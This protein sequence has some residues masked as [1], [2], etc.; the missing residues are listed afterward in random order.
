MSQS[1]SFLEGL[2]KENT[3]GMS[4]PKEKQERLQYI[5]EDILIPASLRMRANV[6]YIDIEQRVKEMHEPKLESCIF[7]ALEHL[8]SLQN[9]QLEDISLQ[10]KQ[11]QKEA[12]VY[13]KIEKTRVRKKKAIRN[14]THKANTMKYAKA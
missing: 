3:V 10:M 9:E 14:Y 7:K 8:H 4:S 6:P 12:T 11:M 2:I 1:G 13:Y 5:F